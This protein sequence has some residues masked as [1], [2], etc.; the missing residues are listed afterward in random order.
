MQTIQPHWID[1][2][3]LI[4]YVAFVLGIGWALSHYMNTSADFLTSAR[5]IPTWVGAATPEN[6]T[7]P[8]EMRTVS[9]SLD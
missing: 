9:G 1:Y 7:M 5:S 2:T 6:K 4:T 8:A 3:I